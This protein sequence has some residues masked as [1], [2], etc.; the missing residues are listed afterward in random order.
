MGKEIRR[1]G[2]GHGAEVWGPPTFRGVE[3]EA[4]PVNK[5]K[6]KCQRGRGNSRT[7]VAM[8]TGK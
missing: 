2:S 7:V 8:K 1:K 3:E 6:K 4:E 5:T